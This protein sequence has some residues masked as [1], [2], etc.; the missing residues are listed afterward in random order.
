[1]TDKQTKSVIMQWL[2]PTV[3]LVIILVVMLTDFSTQSQQAAADNVAKSYVNAAEKYAEEVKY[4]IQGMAAAGKTIIQ[5]ICEEPGISEKKVVE[6]ERALYENSDAYAVVYYGGRGLGVMHDG[7]KVE[8]TEARY[9]QGIKDGLIKKSREQKEAAAPMISYT[10][11]F[12]DEIGIGNSAI[13]AALT[14]GSGEDL[15]LMYYP[16]KKLDGLFIQ[17]EFESNAFYTVISPDGQIIKVNG[18]GQGLVEGGNIWKILEDSGHDSDLLQKVEVRMKN[19][20]SGSFTANIGGVDRRVVYA[21]VGINN[22]TLLVG[23]D[24]SY[25]DKQIDREWSNSENMIYR[26]VMAVGVFLGIVVVINIISRLR[27]NEKRKKLEQKA[28]TDLLTGLNNKLATERKMKEYMEKHP[29]EQ[30]LL[31]VLDVDNFKKI[32]DTLG[33]AFGDEVL[34]ALGHRMASIFRSSDIIGRTGGDEFMILLKKLDSEE[35]LEKEAKKLCDF[36][37]D[38]QVGEYV[39][40][41]ATASIG[42]AVF[43]KDGNDFESMYKAADSALYTAK[44]RGKSQLA[45]YGEENDKSEGIKRVERESKV[46]K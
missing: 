21:P 34:S 32:N 6:M 28:D 4:E 9:F 29:K 26:L 23:I 42:A 24:Q 46:V 3:I 31:F 12:K 27:S 36:F 1:M 43:P 22:W 45:F 13:V 10:Y 33:H 41:A 2:I 37:K 8:I 40:Y 35:I 25:V 18:S 17:P 5:L 39:K 44:K 11:V 14:G 16:V 7:L 15:L 30:A 38:F 19:K 20:T